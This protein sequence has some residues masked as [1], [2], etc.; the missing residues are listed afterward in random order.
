[1]EAKE[2]RIGNTISDYGDRIITV[3]SIEKPIP[4]IK[5]FI[6]VNENNSMYQPDDIQPIPLTE[7]WL[8]KFGFEDEKHI[9][10][11]GRFFIENLFGDRFTFRITINNAESAHANEVKF[12]HQLQNLYFALT[13]IEL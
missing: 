6:S 11:K 3:K 5:H 13:G 7:E 2:L 4:G 10:R 12:V 1:M 9:Y 8:L